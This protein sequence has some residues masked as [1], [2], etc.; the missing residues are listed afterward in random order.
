MECEG[1]ASKIGLLILAT[2]ALCVSRSIALAL[3]TNQDASVVIGQ[4]NFN[5]V[6][7]R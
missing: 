6:K 4:I 5:T 2:V 3:V 1:Y 7:R